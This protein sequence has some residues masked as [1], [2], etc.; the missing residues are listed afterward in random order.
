MKNKKKKLLIDY[1]ETKLDKAGSHYSWNWIKNVNDIALTKDDELD[2]IVMF[3]EFGEEV[4]IVQEW[5]A[6]WK[7]NGRG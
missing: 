2:E 5:I 3:G 6:K 4:E 1:L 7:N